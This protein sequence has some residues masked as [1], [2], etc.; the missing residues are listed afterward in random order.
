MKRLQGENI[1]KRLTSGRNNRFAVCCIYF[2]SLLFFKKSKL[3]I[4]F[5]IA[6]FGRCFFR[7][8]AILSVFAYNHL[9]LTLLSGIVSFRPGLFKGRITLAI[10]RI[11]H[12]PADSVVCFVNIYPLDSD[13]SGG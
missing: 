12:Y 2:S 3:I 4:L 9:V 5:E 8:V 10:H 11:I 7:R 6:A 1:L 13:L